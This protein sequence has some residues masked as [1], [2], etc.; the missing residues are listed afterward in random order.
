MTALR[1]SR[2]CG[3]KATLRIATFLAIAGVSFGFLGCR[4][5][6]PAGG[7]NEP[8]SDPGTPPDQSAARNNDSTQYVDRLTAAG[9]EQRAAESVVELNAEWFAIQKEEN[10]AGL[11]IQ[12]KFLSNLGKHPDLHGFLVDHPETAGLLASASDPQLVA[13]SLRFAAN[14]RANNSDYHRVTGLYVQH[15]SA[16]DVTDIAL[17]LK[18]NHD[19]ICMLLGRGLLGCEALFIFDR[20]SLEAD[21]YETWLREIIESKSAAS[22]EDLASFVNLVMRHG[23]AIRGRMREDEDFRQ[24]FRSVLWPK[25]TNVVASQQGSFEHYLD[26]ERIWD[27]LARENGEVLLRRCGL[28]PI[29]LLYGYPEIDH[30]AYPE[31]LHERIIQILLRRKELAIHSLMKFRREPQF[32]KLLQRDL[33]PDTRSA[34][35]AQLHRS[36]TNYPEKLALYERLGDSALA[37]EV[38]PPPSGIITWVPFYYTLYEV[39]KKRLQGREPTGMDLF[40][41]AVDPLFLIVDVATGGGTV[42][43]RKVLFAG[44]KEAS[45][46][47]GKEMAEKGVG[48]VFVTTLRDTGLDLARNRVGKEVAEKLGEKGLVVWRISGAISQM[49]QMVKSTIGK[50]TTFEIT[51][52]VQFMSRYSGV[53]RETWKRLTGMEAR[54]FMRGDAKVFVRIGNVPVAF[55]GTRSAALLNSTAQ[56]LSIGAMAESDPGQDALHGGVKLVLSAKE[57]LRKWQQNVSAWWLLNASAIDQGLGSTQNE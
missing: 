39:P 37:E 31:S 57:Q 14:N 54:L 4:P 5:S 25:L 23:P 48:K 41:A 2:F 24:R 1:T 15:A 38:G 8:A 29:D 20:E 49:Q 10:P 30:P 36:G 56:D 7:N 42:A 22:D 32:H 40:S 33:S 35:L 44:G 6:A 45:K 12:L 47:V 43:A 51:N 46:R 26:E 21:E 50:L 9:W 27:L 11:E 13:E 18:D 34:A 53:G 55:I 28:L 16:R 17:L 19:L 52:A 3:L